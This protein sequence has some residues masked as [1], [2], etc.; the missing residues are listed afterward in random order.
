M[1]VHGGT[2]AV[3][4]ELLRQLAAAHARIGVVVRRRW[5][6]AAVEQALHTAGVPRARQLVG[7]VDGNDGEAASGLVKGVEDSLGPIDAL[8]S[9]SGAFAS[10]SFGDEPSDTVEQLWQA[11]FAAPVCLARAVVLPMR[12]RRSGT[13]VFTGARAALE[14]A[15]KG[16]AVYVATKM[17]LH[18]FAAALAVELRDCGVGVAVLAPG[19]IDTEANRGAMPNA[20]RGKWVP[21]ADV[22]RRLLGLVLAPPAEPIVA[23]P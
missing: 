22:A 9:A 8:V 11:N 3:G 2:G 10:A 4:T 14:I 13:L 7:V 1:L 6:V 23:C 16:L 5:Q 20:D 19:V 18:A 15:P 21:A 12:R 17:A